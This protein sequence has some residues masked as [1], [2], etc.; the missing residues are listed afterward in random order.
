MRSLLCLVLF[1]CRGRERRA[2]PGRAWQD[3]VPQR[4]GAHHGVHLQAADFSARAAHRRVPRRQPQRRGLP[5]LRH[6]DGRAFRRDRGDA[7]LRRAAFPR[8]TSAAGSVGADGK[9]QLSEA[10]TYAVI[11]KIVAHVRTLENKTAA[12]MPYYL[13]GHSGGRAN[14]LV[15]FRGISAGRRR[16]DRRGESRL[17][18][19]PDA[20]SGLRLR[21]RRAAGRAEQRRGDPLLPAVP[22]TYH[23]GTDDIY[24]RPSFDDSAAAN[25]QASTA[26]RRGRNCFEFARKLAAERGWPSTGA[27]SRRP[28]SATRRP[29][30]SPRRKP[31]MRCLEKSSGRW[32]SAG[33][34][35][36]RVPAATAAAAR[37]SW[38][39]RGRRGA[40]LHSSAP[41]A[42]LR[43]AEQ[44]TVATEHATILTPAGEGAARRWAVEFEQRFR[45]GLR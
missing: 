33:A 25:R 20:R 39:C 9:A 36:P 18:S 26:S 16:A 22:L 8:A 45:R 31:A 40:S 32:A 43:A 15:R 37:A 3:R 12:T 11:P 19:F 14:S 44:W 24:P 2:A 10:W 1:F 42:T 28:A 21:L 35:A 23:L 27:R 13:I 4:H 6:H 38:S 7:A 30:C 41:L 5:Q 34:P 17:G 29:S